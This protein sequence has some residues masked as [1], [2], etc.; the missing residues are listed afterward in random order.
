M[1]KI[2]SAYF[3]YILINTQCTTPYLIDFVA[4]YLML[5]SKC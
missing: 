3:Y 1:Y 4:I 5:Y 2:L